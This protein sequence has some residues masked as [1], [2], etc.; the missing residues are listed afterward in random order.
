MNKKYKNIPQIILKALIMKEL[1]NAKLNSI[2]Y[3]M[4]VLLVAK[5]QK[6]KDKVVHI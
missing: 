2:T 4:I 3:K 5:Y 1:Q 6:E